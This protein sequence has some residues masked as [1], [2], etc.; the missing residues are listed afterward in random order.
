MNTSWLPSGVGCHGSCGPSS[1]SSPVIL[2]I[3]FALSPDI[4]S[5]HDDSA[6]SR[7]DNTNIKD[8]FYLLCFSILPNINYK[9]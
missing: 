9:C 7:N 6:G 1:S 4:G 5:V 8:K 3:G 2:R